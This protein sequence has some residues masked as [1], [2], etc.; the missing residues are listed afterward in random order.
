[1]QTQPRRHGDTEKKSK[2]E[3]SRRHQ[4]D[5]KQAR[6]VMA[7]RRN[8]NRLPGV[9]LNGRPGHRKP[10]LAS[11]CLSRKAGHLLNARSSV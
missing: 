8:Q 10:W 6:I 11:R 4:E 9:L 1:M 3:M 2:K 7:F 5:A